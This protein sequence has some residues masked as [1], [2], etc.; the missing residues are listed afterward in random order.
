[1]SISETESSTKVTYNECGCN[2]AYLFIIIFSLQQSDNK[3]DDENKESVSLPPSSAS[4]STTRY[5]KLST[6]NNTNSNPLEYPYA[7]WF[8]KRQ[9]KG[10]TAGTNY[11]ANLRLVGTFSSVSINLRI[12]HKKGDECN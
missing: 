2:V 4:T 12:E 7:F 8:S 10:I 6:H 9:A 5:S 1:M 11:D 3:I